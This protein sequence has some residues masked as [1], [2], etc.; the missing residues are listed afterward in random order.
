MYTSLTFI[1]ISLVF[2][3]ITLYTDHLKRQVQHNSIE[4]I[5]LVVCTG[6][7]FYSAIISFILACW[8]SIPASVGV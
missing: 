7:C 5:I 6:V 3:F 2:F 1:I 4:H 8:L